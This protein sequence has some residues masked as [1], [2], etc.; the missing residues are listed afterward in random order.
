VKVGSRSAVALLQLPVR[1]RGIRLGQPVDVLLDAAGWRAL[2]LVVLCGDDVKRFLPYAAAQP[3]EDEVAVA[4]ALTLLEDVGFYQHRTDS[5]RALLGCPVSRGGRELGPLRDVLLG[6][7][8][9]ATALVVEREDG[10][11]SVEPQG[12]TVASG[13][14]SAA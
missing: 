8:G 5:L 7:D 14:A 2:G 10:R 3:G 9:V 1:L 4:S 12:A 11:R 6:K 13:R